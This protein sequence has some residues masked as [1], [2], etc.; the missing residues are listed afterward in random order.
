MAMA[1]IFINCGFPL[2][3]AMGGFGNLE[4]HTGIYNSL[5]WL[6]QPVFNIGTIEFSGGNLILIIAGLMV[7]GTALFLNSRLFSSQGVAYA[8]FAGIFWVPFGTTSAIIL[9]ISHDFPGLNILWI[10]FLLVSVL[11][12]AM[13]MVQ[14]PTGGQKTHV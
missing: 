5:A 2:S 12:F 14:L 1:M 8:L 6:T 9:S 7:V 10:I 3:I 4:K 11:I 13:A